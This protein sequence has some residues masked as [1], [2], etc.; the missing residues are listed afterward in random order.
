MNGGDADFRKR[1]GQPTLYARR[2]AHDDRHSLLP[3]EPAAA[4]L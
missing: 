3:L 2:I 1:G 4:T